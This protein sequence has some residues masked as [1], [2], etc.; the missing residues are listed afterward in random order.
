M[1]VNPI[2]KISSL[3]INKNI[4]GVLSNISEDVLVK[5]GLDQSSITYYW[6]T[7]DVIHFMKKTKVY[8]ILVD[9]YVPRFKKTRQI[10]CLWHS[11]KM[12]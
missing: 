5:T 10:E 11:I 8:P 7:L 4:D 2:V 3:A 12:L 6:Q 1:H 9:L